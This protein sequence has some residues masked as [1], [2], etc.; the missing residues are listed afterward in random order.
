M[1]KKNPMM[2]MMM[3]NLIAKLISTF[4]YHLAFSVEG[5]PFHHPM[6]DPKQEWKAV[7]YHDDANS[8]HQ[9]TFAMP[10]YCQQHQHHHHLD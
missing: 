8:F 7:A 6:V 4:S 9:L 5:Y 1:M 10:L 3:M 2:M